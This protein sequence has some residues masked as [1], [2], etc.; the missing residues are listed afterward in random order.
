MSKVGKAIILVGFIVSVIGS[1][2][3]ALVYPDFFDRSL[4]PYFA[5]LIAI[6][7]VCFSFAQNKT[8]ANFGTAF[9]VFSGIFGYFILNRFFEDVEYH[10]RSYKGE[11][12]TIVVAVGLFI[13]LIGAMV[14]FT[15]QLLNLIE[16]KNK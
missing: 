12:V 9:S 7:G 10:G 13:M 8:L 5:S 6:F 4:T 14:T 15:L 3:S 16:H 11:E 2:I 1:F